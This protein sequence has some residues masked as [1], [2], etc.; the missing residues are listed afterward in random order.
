MK[1]IFKQKI[2]KNILF[3][4][5]EKVCIKNTNHFIFDT[6]SYK[7]GQM[8]YENENKCEND[9]FCDK[10]IENYQD[11]KKYYITR[12]N[13]YKK[14]CTILRQICKVNNIQFTKKIIYMKSKYSIKYYI[15]F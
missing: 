8:L 4:Y 9:I 2:D 13:S 11:S 15:Y 3:F 12:D 14:F 6:D 5:L 10:I 1:Q 7:R